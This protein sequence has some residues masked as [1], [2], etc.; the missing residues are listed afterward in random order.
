MVVLLLLTQNMHTYYLNSSFFDPNRKYYT[1]EKRVEFWEIFT[2]LIIFLN[3]AEPYHQLGVTFILILLMVHFCKVPH[4]GKSTPT[5]YFL[6]LSCRERSEQL[7]Q[8]IIG[9][10]P[11]GKCLLSELVGTG[12]KHGTNP[13]ASRGTEDILSKNLVQI[14]PRPPNL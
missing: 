11:S 14:L 12:T 3:S 1:A 10:Y 6:P 9:I 7:L 13:N 5:T 2:G 8:I 4:V